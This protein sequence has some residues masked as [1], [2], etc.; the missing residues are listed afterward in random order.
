ML[1]KPRPHSALSCLLILFLAACGTDGKPRGS[2]NPD[3]RKRYDILLSIDHAAAN[4]VPTGADLQFDIDNLECVPSIPLAGVRPA[5]HHYVPVKFNRI[6]ENVYSATIHVD[7]MKA[8]DLH[9]LGICHWKLAALHIDLAV[10][11]SGD[12]GAFV[13]G[14]GMLGDDLIAQRKQT[15]HFWRDGRARRNAQD[16]SEFDAQG[17]RPYRPELRDEVFSVTLESKAAD[18]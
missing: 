3:P 18:R 9:G 7:A 10:A 15:F 16:P 17:P 2:L 12:D 4:T 5:Q 14:P 8:E 11:R 1:R 13:V 6:S